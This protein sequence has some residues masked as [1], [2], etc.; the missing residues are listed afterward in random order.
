M[1]RAFATDTHPTARPRA[2]IIAV[3]AALA[4][5]ML[6]IAPATHAQEST[7]EAPAAA[8]PAATPAAATDQ[9]GEVLIDYDV[10]E[11]PNAPMTVRLLRITLDPGASVPMHTHPGL[12]FDYVESGTLTTRSDGT[13]V[14]SVDGQ[15]S[16]TSE[17]QTLTEG[18]WVHYPSGVGMNLANEGDEPLVLL[19]AVILSVGADTQ[20]TITY[21]EGDPTDADFEGVSFVVL[22]DGLIQQFPEGGATVI[23][24]ELTVAAGQPVPGYD[25]VAML[26]KASG[27]FAFAA[28]EGLVQVTRTATPQLQPNAIPGQEFTLADNDA[29]FFPAGYEAIERP[30]STG[31]L[32]LTRLLIQPEGELAEAPASVTAIQAAETATEQPTG[33]GL[34]IGA[35]VAITEDGVNVRSEATTDSDIVDSFPAGPQF[36]IIGGPVEGESYTWYEVRGVGDLSDVEGWLVT[37]FMDVIEPAPGGAGAGEGT[38]GASAATPAAA[39]TPAAEGE[40]AVGDTVTTTVEN[41]RIRQEPSTEGEAINTLPLGSELEITGGPREAED[42][43]WYEV[44]VVSTGATGWVASDFLEAA[45]GQ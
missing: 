25:G 34:G 43:T 19:S 27:T 23:V 28:G 12:E 10:A 20:S 40:F 5:L 1:Q 16:E 39:G 21:T 29:A 9:L 2:T 15:Q 35:I 36:E 17:P 26:S 45:G 14:I 13:S 33:D 37:D 32:T 8:S 6:A 22:G 3:V 30:D 11:M 42:Y 44:K 7:P 4:V 31:D 41:L 38:G 18:D 24:D